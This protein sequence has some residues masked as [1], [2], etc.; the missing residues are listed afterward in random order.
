MKTMLRTLFLFALL[1]F[2]V[3]AR[4]DEAAIR[5]SV[6]ALLVEGAKIE[7]ISKAGFLGLYEVRLS[8]PEGVRILYTDED[9]THFFAGAV[10]EAKTQTDL[11]EAR[12]RKLNAIRFQ[13]LPLAQAFKIVRGKGTRQLAYFSDP[14]CP[15]CRKFDQEL[16]RVDDVTVHVFLIPIIA[17]DSAAI[18]KAV[19]CSP[20]R[21]K[22]WLD[23]MLNGVQP[24]AKATCDTPIEKN[25][26]FSRKHG[27]NS[28]PTLIFADG[29]RVPGWMPADRLSK[30]LADAAKR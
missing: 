5:K 23:L 24:T 13:D 27:I 25:L 29:Q 12:L 26:A 14:R 6:E 10:I 18:S 17:P 22:A 30:M 20:D 1:G 28:T 8:T 19:W 4:A 2:A 9:A 21:A 3:A 11:T 16:T 15:Y 7:G